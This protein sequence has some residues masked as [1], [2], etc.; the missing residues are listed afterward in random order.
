MKDKRSA[1]IWIPIGVLLL[2][3]LGYFS[4][5]LILS[6]V[7]YTIRS[8]VFGSSGVGLDNYRYIINNSVFTNAIGNSLA[9]SFLTIALGLPMGL[10][11]ALLLGLIPHRPTKAM[12][13]G[14]F[15]LLALLPDMYWILGSIKAMKGIANA[16]YSTGLISSQAAAEMRNNYWLIFMLGKTLPLISLSACGGLILNLSEKKNGIV[17]ALLVGLIPLLTVL[18]PDLR[19]ALLAGNAMNRQSSETVTTYLYRIGLQNAQISRSGAAGVFGRLISL[20]VGV[21]PAILMGVLAR[22]KKGM[23]KVREEGKP[24][25]MEGLFAMIGAAAAGM[26]VLLIAIVGKP[27]AMDNGVGRAFA[28]SLLS[29]FL[30]AIVVFGV[31][32]GILFFTRYNRGVMG[33]GLIALLLSLLGAFGISGYILARNLGVMNTPIP[34]AFSV[35][36]HPLMIALLIIMIAAKP[37]TGRQVMLTAAG[38]GMLGAMISAGDYFNPNIF[39]SSSKLL[40]LPSMI[41]RSANS[42]VSVEGQAVAPEAYQNGAMVILIVVCLFFGM[43][44]AMLLFWGLGGSRIQ[45]DLRFCP[46]PAPAEESAQAAMQKETPVQSKNE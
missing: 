6:M 13:A 9:Q 2:I 1:L 15:L 38:G 45:Q 7:K 20:F 16:I 27:M 12:F 33:F 18:L 41:W 44:G 19:V 46:Q 4:Y 30:S 5:E 39:I 21:G 40:S 22:R 10:V 37:V 34:G 14:A 32:V 26:L 29:G 3:G 36:G 11:I 25:I 31:C 8:G 28:N 23:L 43:V 42:V 17:G 24:W 35:L